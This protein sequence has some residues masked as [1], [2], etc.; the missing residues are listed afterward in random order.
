MRTMLL[1]VIAV[2]SGC[3]AESEGRPTTVAHPMNRVAE[4]TC[5]A[6]NPTGS[7]ITHTV[8]REPESPDEKQQRVMLRSTLPATPFRGGSRA[9][10]T[11]G[12]RVYR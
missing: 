6:E 10:D 2:I 4:P 5:V 7:N 9:T 1:A 11:P 8:C 3:L 12:L